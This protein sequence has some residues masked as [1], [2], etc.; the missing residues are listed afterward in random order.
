[1]PR[2]STKSL[3]RL[4]EC[5]LPLQIL[6][7]KAINKIDFSILCGYRGKAEQD[8]AFKKGTSKVKFPNSKHNKNPSHAVDIAPYPLNWKD[9]NS[10]IELSKVIKETWN[11]LTEQ[12]KAGWKLEWGGDWPSFKDYPH[13]QITK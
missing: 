5:E 13:Y 10:F 4:A 11:E 2:F 7:S 3:D 9:I 6:M 12:E 1:M 8:I